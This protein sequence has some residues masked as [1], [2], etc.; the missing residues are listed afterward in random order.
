MI[1][2]MIVL[3]LLAITATVFAETGVSALQKIV[4]VYTERDAIAAGAFKNITM[5]HDG[6]VYLW[7]DQTM[8]FTDDRVTPNANDIQ[9]PKHILTSLPYHTKG[10]VIQFYNV[11][12]TTA[13]LTFKIDKYVQ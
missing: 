2:K 7:A 11:S 6:Y 9:V 12:A 8:T 5:T 4:N 13:N 3:L 10:W 1:K